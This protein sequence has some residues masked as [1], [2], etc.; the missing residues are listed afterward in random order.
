MG[1]LKREA[2]EDRYV[3]REGLSDADKSRFVYYL[4]GAGVHD[5]P[6][7][8]FYVPLR[9]LYKYFRYLLVCVLLVTVLAMV[10]WPKCRRTVFHSKWLVACLFV[11]AAQLGV[12]LIFSGGG[13]YSMPVIP[14]LLIFTAVFVDLLFLHLS[15]EETGPS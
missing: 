13:R 12:F 14:L 6:T 4:L 10:L 8:R 11:C 3:L 9:Y 7:P 1:Y 5:F 15:A 2:S